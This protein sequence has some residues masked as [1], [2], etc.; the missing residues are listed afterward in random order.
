MDSTQARRLFGSVLVARFA[1]VTGAGRPHLVPCTF[2]L[3]GDTLYTAVDHKPKTTANLQRLRNIRANPNVAMLADHYEA[4]WA[5]LWWVRADGRASIIDEAASM[6]APLDL[7]AA[8]Y[9]QYAA[10]RPAGPV[11]AI[12]VDRWTGWSARTA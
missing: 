1:T 5:A 4:D 8:R 6:A 9:P 7:L 11:I 3:D 12:D 10:R 2:A